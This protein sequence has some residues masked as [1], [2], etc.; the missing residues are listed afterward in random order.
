MQSRRVEL[1]HLK[2]YT[3]KSSHHDTTSTGFQFEIK[4]I[5]RTPQEA[6]RKMDFHSPA[7]ET[8]R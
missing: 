1:W 7:K 8:R 4:V 3:E 2:D 5:T 6:A